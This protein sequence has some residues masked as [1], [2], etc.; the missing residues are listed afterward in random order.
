MSFTQLS[1]LQQRFIISFIG[2]ICLFVA[3]MLSHHPIFGLFFVTLF[4]AVFTVALWEYYRIAQTKGMQPLVKIGLTGTVGYVF[5]VFLR[6]QTIQAIVLPEIIL[7]LTLMGA[8]LYYFYYF[9]KGTEP[10]LNLAV[11]FF[12]I[13]YLTIPLS[14]LIDINYFSLD[15]T[16]SDGRWALGYLLFVTKIT[17]IGG[18][19]IGKK[20]GKRQLSPGISPKKTWEGAIG[21][22]IC[23]LITSLAL[24]FLLHWYFD[25]PPFDISLFQSVW[26]G[27][28]ISITAQ[29][30]DL[31]ESV[32]KRDVGIKDSNRLPGI[33]GVLDAVD[34]LVFTSPLMYFFLNM[35][36][37]ET[38]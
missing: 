4:A 12:G 17:D 33:G 24:Y 38:L 11:T 9:A 23:A 32:L 22:L 6:T 28:L 19:F 29:F 34:S 14:C 26:L 20:F 7:G 13:I 2:I 10:F 35:Q 5:A 1:N 31:A 27:A 30:G 3:I 16:V 8:F 36:A 15:P 37:V 25:H 21:G 18:F